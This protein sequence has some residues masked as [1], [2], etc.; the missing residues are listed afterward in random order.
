MVALGAVVLRS[1]RNE[2]VFIRQPEII[3]DKVE[4]NYR[5]GGLRVVMIPFR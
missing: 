1:V 2:S 3:E 4:F 5:C